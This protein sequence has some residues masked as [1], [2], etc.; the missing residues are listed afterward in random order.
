MWSWL[1]V[2]STATARAPRRA[3]HD[4]TYAV[5]HPSSTVRRP[6]R[7]SGSRPTSDSSIPKM[8]HLGRLSQARRPVMRWRPAWP[9]H[10]DTFAV[11]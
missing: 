6:S 7:W 11:R 1:G 5:P 9:S 2:G 3:S 10:C 8:P 4:E